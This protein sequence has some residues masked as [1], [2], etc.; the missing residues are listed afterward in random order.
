MILLTPVTGSRFVFFDSPRYAD[1]SAIYKP[2]R[3]VQRLSFRLHRRIVNTSFLGHIR[4]SFY[5]DPYGAL[6][7]TQSMRD[8]RTLYLPECGADNPAYL[9]TKPTHGVTR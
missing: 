7:H 3:V 8:H 4:L 5:D 2:L 1:V 9:I 6:S